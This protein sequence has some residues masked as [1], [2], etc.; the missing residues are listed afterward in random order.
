MTWVARPWS[1]GPW[2]DTPAAAGG[3]S[4]DLAQTANI[5]LTGAAS[6]SGDVQ[7][8]TQLNL[9]QTAAVA[10][11]GSV[12][13]SGDIQILTAALD[14]AQ[15]AAVALSGSASVSGDIQIGTTF[16]LAQS[17]AVGLTGSAS[18]TGNV[19]IGVGFDLAQSGAVA[20]SGAAAVSGDIASSTTDQVIGRRRR[21]RT[22]KPPVEQAE[23]AVEKI[24]APNV[25]APK[26]T[27]MPDAQHIVVASVSKAE[28]LSKSAAVKRRMAIEL[29]DEQALDAL[30]MSYF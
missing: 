28:R 20:L 16:N 9:S 21:T 8:G 10:L 5:A 23:E 7:I 12:S 17:A 11:A 15:T 6:V 1:A 30:L 13:V 27:L 2:A 24:A 4:L 3:T 18:V 26:T 29:A 19:Q 25:K 22:Y 14:L